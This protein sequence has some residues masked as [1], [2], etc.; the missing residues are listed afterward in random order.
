MKSN[1][2]K[3]PGSLINLEVALDV[4]EFS[5]YWE[6]ARNQALNLVQVKG[7]RPGTAPKELAE[8]GLDKEKVFGK[9]A[10]EAVRV[11]LNKISQENDWVMIDKPK[12]EITEGAPDS[13][14]KYQAELVVFPEIKLANYKKI[15]KEIL[16]EKKEIA[17]SP[18]EVEKSLN[19]VRESRAKLIRVDRTAG[20]G[21]AVDVNIESS[22]HGK[23][24]PGGTLKGD[25]FVLGESRF[26]PGFDDQ[27]VNHCA[28]EALNFS[29]TAGDDYWNKD[30]RGKT[31]DFR[32]KINGVF[33]R[34]LAELNDDFAKSLGLSF[35]T[36]GE[37][38][39]SIESGLKIEKEQKEQDRIRVKIIEE[40][41]KASK[42]DTPQI[43]IEKTLDGLVKEVQIMTSVRE[44]ALSESELRRELAPRAKQRVLADLVI[45]KI[46]EQEKLEPSREEVE[47]EGQKLNLDLKTHYDYSYSTVRN[48]KLFEF[49]E[50]K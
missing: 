47:A 39:A 8:Q 5:S 26:M 13:G 18:E 3:G 34:Q 36:I 37:V 35:S 24:L 10:E 21:D 38:K 2:K 49:L 16:T 25:R 43:L 29:L 14:L 20:R 48:R 4:K 22:V 42:I 23:L 15:A 7:F 40:I 12:I 17:V 28:G 44:P 30:L 32:I 31:V 1:F 41:I 46:V 50:K 6:D 33:S 9:A 19:W 27:L 45:Y 11:S